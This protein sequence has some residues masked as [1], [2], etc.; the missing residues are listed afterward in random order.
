MGDSDQVNIVV[1]L[2]R[3]ESGKFWSTH[4]V[5]SE[6]DQKKL[7]EWFPDCGYEQIS[8][9]LFAESLRRM[10]HL[11]VLLHEQKASGFIQKYKEGDPNTRSNMDQSIGLEIIQILHPVLN[12][13]APDIAREILTKLSRG[14]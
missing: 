3:H 5:E 13:L 9:S 12:K 10:T 7:E 1:K 4:G 6:E 14:A 2:T 11:Q 8:M